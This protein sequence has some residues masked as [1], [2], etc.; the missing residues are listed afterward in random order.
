MMPHLP[1]ARSGAR[2]LLIAAVCAAAA[3][4]CGTAAAP[5]GSPA[6]AKVSLDIKVSGGSG[7]AHN[8]TLLCDPA[9]GTHPNPA[10][11]C[12][13][14]LKAKDP[15]APA[16]RGLMCPMIAASAR[17][18]TVTGIYFGQHINTTITE[19]GCDGARWTRIGQLFY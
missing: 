19:G 18:A 16:P 12:T 2:Y 15:F 3:T 10:A 7:G 8:W 1:R 6:P 11:A 4:A 17:V 9:G 14:L 5:A 13:V